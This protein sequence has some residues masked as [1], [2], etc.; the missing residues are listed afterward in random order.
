MGKHPAETMSSLRTES[1]H[2]EAEPLLTTT[3]VA[4]LFS[5]NKTYKFGL[6]LLRSMAD[7]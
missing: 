3:P 6:S 7:S 5:L 1:V 2:G 4:V